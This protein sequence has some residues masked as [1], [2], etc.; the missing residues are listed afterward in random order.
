MVYGGSVTGKVSGKLCKRRRR[1][2]KNDVFNKTVLSGEMTKSKQRGQTKQDQEI[3]RERLQDAEIIGMEVEK[4]EFMN[5]VN[6]PHVKSPEEMMDFWNEV[7]P[8]TPI[9]RPR[10]QTEH[11]D[12]D[13]AQFEAKLIKLGPDNVKKVSEFIF[14]R[15][16]NVDLLSLNSGL[17]DCFKDAIEI[18]RVTVATHAA[19]GKLEREAIVISDAAERAIS[20]R[21]DACVPEGKRG[22]DE[23]EAVMLAMTMAITWAEYLAFGH[24]LH[25][26][27][28]DVEFL[29]RVQKYWGDDD[30][31]VQRP[32]GL[33]E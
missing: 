4:L 33:R 7:V 10:S 19:A 28:S 14:E 30:T 21:A 27:S 23:M 16:F 13:K 1:S 5:L 31:V 22:H 9:F 26:K 17:F 3:L 12:V 25:L 11:R 29:E 18:D 20:E 2:P 24:L 15:I 32:V 8:E 6:N